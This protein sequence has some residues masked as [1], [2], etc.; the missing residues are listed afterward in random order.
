MSLE[1]VLPELLRRV[2]L[3]PFPPCL[4]PSVRSYSLFMASLGP[5]SQAPA[6]P[7]VSEPSL[8]SRSLIREDGGPGTECRHLQQL[9]VRRVGEICR[10]VNQVRDSWEQGFLGLG[11]CSERKGFPGT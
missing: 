4:P 9:L 1:P 7:T 8:P 2:S 11:H 5:S 3:F 10:E 6:P